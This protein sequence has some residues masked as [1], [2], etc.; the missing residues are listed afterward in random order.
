MEQ[1]SDIN[2]KHDETEN[3]LEE[4]RS[5]QLYQQHQHVQKIIQDNTNELLSS[6]LTKTEYGLDSLQ[7]ITDAL[8]DIINNETDEGKKY[9]QQGYWIRLLHKLKAHFINTMKLS[10]DVDLNPNANYGLSEITL[11]YILLSYLS[12]RKDLIVKSEIWVDN[13]R[14][15]IYIESI[16]H[17]TV[18]IIELKYIRIPYLLMTMKNTSWT[19]WENVKEWKRVN[20]IIQSSEWY[21][22]QEMC[23]NEKTS[24][25]KTEEVTIH[26]KCDEAWLQLNKY[27]TSIQTGKKNTIPNT[28]SLYKSVMIGLG[29]SLY[30]DNIKRH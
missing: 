5:Y 6:S 7:K 25:D 9:E 3:L 27:A 29:K 16:E 12:F 15:D 20:D 10:N 26:H 11:K 14:I 22:I 21:D 4:A 23:F 8:N 30:I 18:L 17:D 13:G 19:P 1:S 24:G 2:K 28:Y